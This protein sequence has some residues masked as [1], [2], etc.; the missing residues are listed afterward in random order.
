MRTERA[1]HNVVF[2]SEELSVKVL[3][4]KQQLG[5]AQCCA[6]NPTGIELQRRCCSKVLRCTQPLTSMMS[7]R[8]LPARAAECGDPIRRIIGEQ[9]ERYGM[10][11]PA[12]HDERKR[13]W[14]L[15]DRISDKMRWMRCFLKRRLPALMVLRRL[16]GCADRSSSNGAHRLTRHLWSLPQ[17]S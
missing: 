4:I 8:A 15:S 3:R 10:R 5:G 1:F 13:P 14:R 16:A 6:L 11:G 9:C 2:V 17:L 12:K 7:P